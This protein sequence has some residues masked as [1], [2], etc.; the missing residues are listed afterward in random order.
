MT[1][2]MLIHVTF[3]ELFEVKDAAGKVWHFEWHDYCGVTVLR[4][5]GKARRHQPSKE[6]AFWPAFGKWLKKHRSSK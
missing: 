2:A 6:S 3:R 5:D 1:I 4:K